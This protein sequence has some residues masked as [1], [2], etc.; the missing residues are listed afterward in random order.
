MTTRYLSLVLKFTLYHSPSNPVF[1]ERMKHIENDCH[2][3]HIE[4]VSGNIAT[5]HVGT[6][7]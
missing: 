4:L 6:T 7:E 3:I 5:A 1:H 2:F